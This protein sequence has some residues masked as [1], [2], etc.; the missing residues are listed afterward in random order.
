MI[1][2][3]IEEREEKY[4]HGFVCREVFVSVAVQAEGAYLPGVNFEILSSRAPK[5]KNNVN[6][7]LS[8]ETD[9]V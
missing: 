8:E 6:I 3:M 7:R 2:F 4:T 1:P 5:T 9:H